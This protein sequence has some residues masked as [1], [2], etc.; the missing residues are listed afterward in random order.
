MENLSTV[1]VENPVDNLVKEVFDGLI[2]KED[3]RF[4]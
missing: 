3:Y 1:Y 2:Y 4:A